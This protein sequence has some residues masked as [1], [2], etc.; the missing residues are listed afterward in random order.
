MDCFHIW[1]P[2]DS[3]TEFDPKTT[4]T[5]PIPLWRQDMLKSKQK[6]TTEFQLPFTPQQG[7]KYVY[8][9]KLHNSLIIL[10]SHI[11]TDL[12]TRS[13]SLLQ[14]YWNHLQLPFFIFHGYL[15]LLNC[16]PKENRD[17]SIRNLLTVPEREISFPHS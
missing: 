11:V 14:I 13:H 8:Q 3:N 12:E 5:N 10:P 17:L 6:P 15:F 4:I 1:H 2:L 16:K 7:K 9:L